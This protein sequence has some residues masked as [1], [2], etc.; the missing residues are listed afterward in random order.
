[1]GWDRQVEGAL[2][3]SWFVCGQGQV[4]FFLILCLLL[5]P[6][7]SRR[8]SFLPASPPHCLP[9]LPFVVPCVFPIPFHPLPLLARPLPQARAGT[10]QSQINM[11]EVGRH[12]QAAYHP[13][14]QKASYHS[15]LGA[16]S[17]H[18]KEREF[19]TPLQT[20]KSMQQHPLEGKTSL[21]P[22]WAGHLPLCSGTRN[23]L[24]HT[25][26]MPLKRRILHPSHTSPKTHLPMSCA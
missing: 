12:L 9:P 23:H 22:W 11:L 2:V 24:S 16:Y 19:Y 13:F 8:P 10:C 26:I 3:D 15:R 1:M 14:P 21:E 5:C 25:T 18:R 4:Y 20:S 6:S 17:L 7:F